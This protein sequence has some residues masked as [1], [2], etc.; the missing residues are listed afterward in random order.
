MKEKSPFFKFK[1]FLLYLIVFLYVVALLFPI[2]WIL[3]TSLQDGDAISFIPKRFTLANYLTIFTSDRFS[4]VTPLLNSLRVSLTT[5]AICILLGI[6]SAYAFARLKFKGSSTLFLILIFT[7]MLPPIALLIP[8]FLLYQRLHLFN[9]WYGLV[10]GY[11]AWL[12]PITTWVLYSYFQSIPK[13]LE[14]A[15]RADGA[16]RVGALFKI[17]LPVSAPGI[18]AAT[19][20]CFMFSMGE[21]LFAIT[22]A[23][24]EKAHTLTVNMNIFIT[25]FQIEYGY[26][27]ATTIITLLFPV[28]L[29]LIL[30]RFLIDGLTKGAVKE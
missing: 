6:L 30:Q 22:V 2:Y 20:I 9:T 16:T 26:L 17:I 14:E 27:T 19:V 12:L 25:K 11:V 28:I 29:V 18:I 13:D 24:A 21:F 8:F 1:R 15:A 3:V 7:E 10:I 23:T 5:T 4:I